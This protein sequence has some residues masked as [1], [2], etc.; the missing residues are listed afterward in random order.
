MIFSSWLFPFWCFWHVP[1]IDLV[2]P[3]GYQILPGLFTPPRGSTLRCRNAPFFDLFLSLAVTFLAF[4]TFQGFTVLRLSFL[5]VKKDPVTQRISG[6]FRYEK[7]K[8]NEAYKSS[9]QM[10]LEHPGTLSSFHFLRY[11]QRFF[12]RSQAKK[13]LEASQ[14]Q[15][16]KE[17]REPFRHLPFRQPAHSTKIGTFFLLSSER[18]RSRSCACHQCHISKT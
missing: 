16:L 1:A 7:M 9:F 6:I 3:G 13:C 14:I 12:P 11:M 2:I 5:E 18:C 10:D 4:Q 8:H 15:Y 17:I